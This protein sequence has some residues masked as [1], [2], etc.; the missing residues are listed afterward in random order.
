[1]RRIGMG[2]VYPPNLSRKG[3]PVRTSKQ[4]IEIKCRCA[5]LE[6]VC[7]K[8]K[9]L[10]AEDKGL[11]RQRDTFFQG[12]KA[13]I[14][15]REVGEKAE[16]ISYRRKDAPEA[17]ASDYVVIPVADPE[18]MR[19]VLDHGLGEKGVVKKVRHLFLYRHTRIHLDEVE[20]LGSF[21][22]LETVLSDID[23]TEGR[24]ELSEVAEALGLRP[25]D[26]LAKPYVELLVEIQGKAE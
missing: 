6:K 23:E 15:L 8:A 10:G 7:Q 24:K 3:D 4:N 16:L 13:R 1:M 11:L 22:E 12:V 17:R 9:K 19:A 25:E 5:D 21:V 26:S 18:A 2:V 14:K 20:G